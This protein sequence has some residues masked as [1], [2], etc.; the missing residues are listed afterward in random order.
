VGIAIDPVLQHVL[1]WV[2][3]SSRRADAN[4][5]KPVREKE[6]IKK[7]FCFCSHSGVELSA[8]GAHLIVIVRAAHKSII[9]RAL[10]N[11]IARIR[12]SLN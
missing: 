4:D 10:E 8:L 2:A 12:L 6:I 1:L 3:N 5:S 7:S 9:Q 11:G